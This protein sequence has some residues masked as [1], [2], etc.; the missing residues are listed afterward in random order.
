VKKKKAIDDGLARMKEIL[1][2]FPAESR[3]KLVTNDFA[4]FSTNFKTKSEI[5]EILSTLRLSPISRSFDEVLTRIDIG[6]S[7]TD[8]FWISDFQE[9]TLGKITPLDTLN[10][11]HLVPITFEQSISNVYVDSV[12]RDNPFSIAGEKNSISVSLKNNGNS[13]RENIVVKLVINDTQSATAAITL[14]PNGETTTNFDLPAGLRRR[15]YAKFMINDFP[16]NFDNEFYFTLNFAEKIKVIEIKTGAENSPIAAVFGNKELFSFQLFSTANI[17]YS[18]V[19]DATFVVLNGLPAIDAA[20]QTTLKEYQ[21]KGGIVMLIPAAKP[22]LSTYQFLIEKGSL[23][24]SARTE[25]QDLSKPDF[26]NPFFNN[27]FE[28]KAS[29]ILMP[30]GTKIIDWGNDRSAILTLKDG[31]P[32]LS[33]LGN[34][35]ILSAPLETTYTDFNNHA[36]FVPIMYRLSA[37]GKKESQRLYYSLD[38]SFISIKRDSLP[39]EGQIK[40]QGDQEIIPTQR[41]NG[42]KVMLEL[43][44]YLINKGFYQITF[45]QDTLDYIGLNLSKKESLLSQMS[46]EK[47]KAALGGGA[48]ISIFNSKDAASFGTEIKERYVGTSL[49]KQALLLALLFLLTEV[50]LIRF[51]K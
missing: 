49:W 46:G 35:V 13:K 10:Q 51:L 31:Q 20:L 4:P 27:V 25:M 34:T 26:Q 15:N 12:Y 3:F 41:R 30:K 11:W 24:L 37:S 9:S 18:L 40:L 33:Q 45:K 2:V 6:T 43:P 23:S 44:R 36:L 22:D 47:M 19:K 39:Q 48:H 38:E 50:L 14:E 1:T 29:T 8:I 16:V 32:F 7:V 17:N 42:D 28:E 21:Q 5:E